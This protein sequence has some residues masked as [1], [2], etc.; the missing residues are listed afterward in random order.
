M[1]VIDRVY[2]ASKDYSSYTM[3]I[4]SEDYSSYTMA[5]KSSGTYFPMKHLFLSGRTF[6]FHSIKFLQSYSTKS[7]VLGIN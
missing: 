6:H 4:A 2:F 5:T 7:Y 3:A 1:P